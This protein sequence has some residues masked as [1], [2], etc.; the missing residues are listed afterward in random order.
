MK[1]TF[2]SLLNDTDLNLNKIEIPIIQRDYVQG[3][4]GEEIIRDNF[5]EFLVNNIVTGNKVEV[6][7]IYG[8]ILN[9]SN[10]KVFI[11][12]DGQQRLTTLFLLHWYIALHEKKLTPA[13]QNIL[14][15]FNYETRPSTSQFCK[16]IL[17]EEITEEGGSLVDRIKNSNW[18]DN[19]WD[20]DNSISAM[21]NVIMAFSSCSNLNTNLGSL[22][23]GLINDELVSFYFVSLDD[24]GLTENI[25]LRMNARGKI[26]TDFENFKSEFY[27]Y[28]QDSEFA[29]EIKDSIEYKW[30]ESLWGYRKDNEFVIDAPFMNYLAFITEML[31]FKESE[32]RADRYEN[33]FCDFRVLRKIYSKPEN[34]AFLKY[35]LDIIPEIKKM[36]A[37]VIPWSDNDSLSSILRKIAKGEKNDDVHIILLYSAL[38]YLYNNGCEDSFGDFIRVVRNLFV[39]TADRSRREW[40]RILGSISKLISKKPV[41]E[42]LLTDIVLEGFFVPQ[43]NEEVFKAK[44][45]LSNNGSVCKKLICEAENTVLQGNITSLIAASYCSSEQDISNFKI[46]DADFTTFDSDMFAVLFKGYKNI[47]IKDFNG[48][49]GDLLITSVYIHQSWGRLIYAD[50]YKKSNGLMMWNREYVLSQKTLDDFI[51]DQEKAFIKLMMMKYNN[52]LEESTNVREQ[53][54]IYYIISRR[55]LNISIESFFSNGYN[56]GWLEKETGYTSIFTHGIEGDNWFSKVNPI[57]QTYPSQFRYNCGLQSKNALNVEVVG[58]GRPKFVFEKLAEWAKS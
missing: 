19:E 45:L 39:N 5:V 10:Q 17:F 2:W 4:I 33:N 1:Y 32:F 43:R 41:L 49:W 23:E 31:Y 54:Y 7:F 53:L 14:C 3:R 44:L 20:H 58:N 12:V 29:S 11:P 26:L 57:F 48:V 56:F 9:S 38:T 25:Y 35:A 6:D 16:N 40:S 15:K 13:T 30:V 52:T 8:S 21:L 22:F 55:L 34:V 24:F 27:K 18:Y 46:S 37:S 50:S 36:T 51:I 28:I 42:L 47:A